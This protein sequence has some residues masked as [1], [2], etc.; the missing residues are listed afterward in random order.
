MVKENKNKAMSLTVTEGLTVTVLPHSDHEFLMTTKQVASGYG[1]SDYIVRKTKERHNVELVEG[2][3][4]VTAVTF[5]HGETH[6]ALKD[7]NVPHNAI[8]WTKRGIVRLG[9]F[10]KSKRARMFR[11][12][13]EELVV[14]FDE[15]QKE[16]FPENAEIKNPAKAL[17]LKRNHNRLT[18]DRLADL[19][20]D[21]CHIEDKEL[22]L[23]ITNKLMEG[24]QR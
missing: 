10:I 1:T 18:K 3:H 15:N 16:L 5:S 13:A 24:G 22:R 2:K 21:V 4:F 14:R 20:A 19:L 7:L 17:P 6:N 8:I 23:R 9:F 12:W 11:D